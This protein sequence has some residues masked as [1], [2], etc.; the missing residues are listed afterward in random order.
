MNHYALL[1]LMTENGTVGR[2]YM[3]K[4]ELENES[5]VFNYQYLYQDLD[6]YYQKCKLF[7]TVG[8]MIII[9]FIYGKFVDLICR[10]EIIERKIK[11]IGYQQEYV[12]KQLAYLDQHIMKMQQNMELLEEKLELLEEKLELLEEK[13]ELLAVNQGYEIDSR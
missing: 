12:F 4:V 9:L 8:A 11:Q 6:Q 7:L 2:V 5:N 13:L 10:T 3:N 1:N